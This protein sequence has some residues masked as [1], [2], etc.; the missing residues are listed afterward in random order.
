M[1][2]L[3][4]SLNLFPIP[5]YVFISI[6]LATYHCFYFDNYFIYAFSTGTAVAA[7]LIFLGYISFFKKKD[8]SNSFLSKNINYVIGTITGLVALISLFKLFFKD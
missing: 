1:G 5:Y 4:S 7:F 3:L 6:T 2:V 8:R